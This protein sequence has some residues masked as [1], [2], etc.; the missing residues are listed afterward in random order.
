MQRPGSVGVAKPAIRA[1]PITIALSTFPQATKAITARA[2][3]Y[4]N[5]AEAR[6]VG[7]ALSLAPGS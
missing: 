5:A 7:K 3:S 1:F 4:T 6:P 2:L